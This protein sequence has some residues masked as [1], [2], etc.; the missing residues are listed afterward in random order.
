MISVAGMQ[1]MI[2]VNNTD[3][4]AT[5]AALT[6]FYDSL[7]QE[8]ALENRNVSITNIYPYLVDTQLF[9]GF[10]GRALWI[11]PALKKE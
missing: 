9:A 3:Y 10:S 4:A 11:I 6:A 7:R 5:K 1:G 2:A 8:M